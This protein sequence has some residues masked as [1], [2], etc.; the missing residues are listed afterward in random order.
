VTS[1]STGKWKHFCKEVH[2]HHHERADERR[3][4]FVREYVTQWYERSVLVRYPL[5]SLPKTCTHILW[6]VRHICVFYTHTAGRQ[7]R[8]TINCSVCLTLTCR[9]SFALATLLS[10]YLHKASPVQCT[11]SYL[12]KE[13]VAAQLTHGRSTSNFNSHKNTNVNVTTPKDTN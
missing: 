9:M 7:S 4:E 3:H 10:W 11:K 2:N 8:Q 12:P 13:T 1:P 6:I 5:H